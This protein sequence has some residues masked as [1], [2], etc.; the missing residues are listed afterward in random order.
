MVREGRKGGERE[1]VGGWEG[2]GKSLTYNDR[3]LDTPLSY[4]DIKKENDEI[5]NSLETTEDIT[6]NR[7]IAMEKKLGDLKS[8]IKQMSE[9]RQHDSN[10]DEIKNKLR[11]MEDR[12]RRNNL[13]IDGIPERVGEKDHDCKEKIKE[14]FEN[15]LGFLNIVIER[16]IDEGKKSAW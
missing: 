5:K 15:K 4:V 7:I 11:D 8:K 12:S 14:V 1:G 6:E 2:E 10:L 3:I 9:T 13:R 16:Y